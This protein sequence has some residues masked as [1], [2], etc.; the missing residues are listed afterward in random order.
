MLLRALVW[1]GLEVDPLALLPVMAPMWVGREVDPLLLL[2][3]MAPMWVG[4]EVDPLA[5]QLIRGSIKR[6]VHHFP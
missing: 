3:L 5:V 6:E 1:V 4:Q 2:P